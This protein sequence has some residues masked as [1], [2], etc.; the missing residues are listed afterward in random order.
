MRLINHNGHTFELTVLDYMLPFTPGHYFANN[1][2][3][4]FITLSYCDGIKKIKL[5]SL[6]TEELMKLMDWL[7][8]LLNNRIQSSTVFWFIDPSMKFRLWKTGRLEMI[9]FIY[10]SVQKTT[11]SWDMMLN[12]ET[13]TNFRNQLEEILINVPFR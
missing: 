1:W 7:T 12:A 11:Y 5:E 3:K 2:L 9:K 8:S 10:H 13:V 4:G 6:Q